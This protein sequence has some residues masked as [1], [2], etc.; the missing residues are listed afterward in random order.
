MLNNNLSLYNVSPACFEL[1]TANL[2]EVSTEYKNGRFRSSCAYVESKSFQ[3]KLIKIFKIYHGRS[4]N[5]QLS[6]M[7]EAPTDNTGITPPE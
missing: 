5:T 2:T 3:V 1:F 7:V 6:T 4:P